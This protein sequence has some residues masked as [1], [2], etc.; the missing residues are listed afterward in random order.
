MIPHLLRRLLAL[1]GVLLVAAGL[2]C[3]AY[4]AMQYSKSQPPPA[5]KIEIDIPGVT[6]EAERPTGSPELERFAIQVLAGSAGLAVGGV[7]VL[8]LASRWKRRLS[9]R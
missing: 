4:G 9:P 1:S 6:V 8:F 3:A 2:L 7:V 5:E